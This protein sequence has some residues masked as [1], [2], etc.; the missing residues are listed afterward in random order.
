M[1]SYRPMSEW[2]APKKPAAQTAPPALSQA[3][4]HVAA[5]VAQQ[6]PRAP[7]TP[8]GVAAAAAHD[9]LTEAKRMALELHCD[10]RKA[11][12]VVDAKAYAAEHGCDFIAACKALGFSR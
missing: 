6:P 12:Q 8:P 4:A 2:H 9:R 5:R 7:S 1:N 11:L 10:E 3:P